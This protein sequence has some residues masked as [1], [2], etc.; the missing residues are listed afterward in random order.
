MKIILKH[1]FLTQIKSQCLLPQIKAVAAFK[2]SLKKKDGKN[3]KDA[4]SVDAKG[5]FQT[6]ICKLSPSSLAAPAPA[7][8]KGSSEE[9]E[10]SGSPESRK[11]R[12]R[13][14]EDDID[15]EDEHKSAFKKRNI[16]K[17]DDDKNERAAA[18]FQN[19]FGKIRKSKTSTSSPRH[20][21]S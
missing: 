8:C 7:S 11:E 20:G 1:P 14:G 21:V 5:E 2:R 18:A 3:G 12:E 15:I 17:Y 10:K 16:V 4:D 13:R 19:S 6:L 9:K